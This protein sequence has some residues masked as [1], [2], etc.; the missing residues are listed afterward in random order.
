[1]HKKKAF[2]MIEVMC[3]IC[4][5]ALAVLPMIWLGSSQTKGAYSAS[6]HMMAGQL[7]A[8]F[9]DNILKRPYDDLKAVN[10]KDLKVNDPAPSDF[11]KMFNLPELIESLNGFT[12]DEGIRSAEEN[13]KASFKNFKYSIEITKSETNVERVAFITVVVSYLVVEGQEKTRQ[14]VTLSALKFGEKNG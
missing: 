5:F 4:I 13:M 2:S 1:M 12:N 14:S 10:L 6:K 8:S 9:M 11:D 3:A 7:A